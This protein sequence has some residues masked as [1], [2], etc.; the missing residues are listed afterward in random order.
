[1]LDD[2][3]DG[4]VVRIAMGVHRA[5]QGSRLDLPATCA[6]ALDTIDAAVAWRDRK[7]FEEL[8]KKKG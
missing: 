5:H 2:D 4:G 6:D 8:S 3:A 7:H 1:M